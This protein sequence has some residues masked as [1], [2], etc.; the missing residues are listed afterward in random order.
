ML[1]Y[2]SPWVFSWLGSSLFAT[3]PTVTS[4]VSCTLMP[5]Y[6]SLW[7]TWSLNAQPS[8]QT[9]SGITFMWCS[10]SKCILSYIEIVPPILRLGS[11][12]YTLW[13]RYTP[14]VN[15]TGMLILSILNN[16]RELSPSWEA[17]SH[18]STQ[19]IRIKHSQEQRSS[20]YEFTVKQTALYSAMNKL[21]PFAEFYYVCTWC[22]VYNRT[23]AITQKTTNVIRSAHDVLGLWTS[24]H[25]LV[26]I[27]NTTIIIFTA[28]RTSNLI[29]L[30]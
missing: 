22:A 28:V 9:H 24:E 25:T 14:R 21:A 11:L 7:Q 29:H 2:V 13:F 12:K 5:V 18:L 16:S 17:N 27:Q 3:V 30:S 8:W 26:I 10:Q 4:E 15:T 6:L 20:V 23:L 1:T 19:A